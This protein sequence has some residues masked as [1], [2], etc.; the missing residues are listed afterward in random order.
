MSIKLN[1][2]STTPGRTSLRV[3]TLFLLALIFG[4]GASAYSVLT[5][6]EIID[7]V[8]KDEIRPLLVTRFPA[9]TEE[10]ITEAHAYAY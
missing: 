7:L 4:G 1:R 10:Q 6:E 5:H 8:W 9:M 3:V 2:C